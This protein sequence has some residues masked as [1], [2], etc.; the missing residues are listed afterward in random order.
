MTALHPWLKSDPELSKNKDAKIPLP[1]ISSTLEFS[2]EELA[3]RVG[4]NIDLAATA[5]L[6]FPMP[7]LPAWKDEPNVAQNIISTM[8]T[9]M[10]ARTPKCVLVPF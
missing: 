7:Q 1:E 3:K 9:T 2:G 5:I 8:Q 6:K 10:V 4:G